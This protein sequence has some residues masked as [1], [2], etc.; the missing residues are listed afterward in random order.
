MPEPAQLAGRVTI[1]RLRTARS[2]AHSTCAAVAC[3]LWIAGSL[4]GTAQA[5]SGSNGTVDDG[6]F[7]GLPAFRAG[8]R[9]PPRADAAA[10][11][12]T[13]KPTRFWLPVT[14]ASTA[15][16]PSLVTA[17]RVTASAPVLE[18]SVSVGASTRVQ[19]S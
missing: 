1:R 5:R 6:V 13:M 19:P 18:T 12:W 4:R 14:V 2:A 11:G 16:F 17:V 3:R 7:A 10:L 9:T 8:D 15:T